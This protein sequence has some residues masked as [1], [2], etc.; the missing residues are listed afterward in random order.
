VVWGIKAKWRGTTVGRDRA[1][2]TKTKNQNEKIFL[3]K[4]TRQQRVL[5]AVASPFW[6]KGERLRTAKKIIYRPVKLRLCKTVAVCFL[7]WFM[8]LQETC[9]CVIQQG[10]FLYRDCAG[11]IE[12]CGKF[13]FLHNHNK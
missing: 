12:C 3:E 4:P 1:L 5:L 6:G 9:N 8:V 2:K 13:A 7:G 11:K 10:V